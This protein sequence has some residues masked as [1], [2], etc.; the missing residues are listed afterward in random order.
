MDESP[1]PSTTR[2]FIYLPSKAKRSHTSS[3]LLASHQSKTW[4]LS[5]R[6]V[7]CFRSPVASMPFTRSRTPC[8]EGP[9]TAP[10]EQLEPGG[11]VRFEALIVYLVLVQ[12]APETLRGTLFALQQRSSSSSPTPCRRPANPRY[13]KLPPPAVSL[14]SSL[15]APCSLRLRKRAAG[16]R[17]A[18]GRE[19][20]M[21]FRFWRLGLR[22]HLRPLVL[23]LFGILLLC[24]G[25]VLL[26]T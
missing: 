23:L 24:R 12:A 13:P 25:C 1:S 11:V 9:T 7:R 26:V 15:P 19:G 18:G 2:S 4:R 6:R 10:C 3:R 8:R 16:R 21:T 14:E 22:S 17:R 5:Q 20:A